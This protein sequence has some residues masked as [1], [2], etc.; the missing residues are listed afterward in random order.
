M[1]VE[2]GLLQVYSFGDVCHRRAMKSL[3]TKDLRSS[4]QNVIPGHKQ[5]PTERSVVLS[6]LLRQA[7]SRKKRLMLI[8]GHIFGY[9]LQNYS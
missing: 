4:F 3:L 1:M 8:S 6:Y 7:M 2:A 5:L 9:I